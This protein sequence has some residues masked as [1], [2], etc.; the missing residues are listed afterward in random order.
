MAQVVEKII[1]DE[2]RHCILYTHVAT[3][4]VKT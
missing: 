3:Q 2:T 4:K 1:L